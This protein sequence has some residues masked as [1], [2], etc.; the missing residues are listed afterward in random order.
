MSRFDLAPLRAGEC[1][2]SPHVKGLPVRFTGKPD[3]GRLA[4]KPGPNLGSGNG[5]VGR[6]DAV[7]VHDIELQS[8]DGDH[9]S[10]QD[11]TE[12]PNVHVTSPSIIPQWSQ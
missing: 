8:H 7:V 12:H 2:T 11:R 3:L 5:N 1:Q 4:S 9:G 6:T 10:T